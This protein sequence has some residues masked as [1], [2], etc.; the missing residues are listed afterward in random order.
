[1][2]YI[3]KL[4]DGRMVRRHKDHVRPYT[5]TTETHEY[6]NYKGEYLQSP[7]WMEEAITEFDPIIQ[8]ESPQRVRY[9]TKRYQPED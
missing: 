1:M 8:I 6:G 2:S 9:P 7:Q 3:I 4:D 5:L